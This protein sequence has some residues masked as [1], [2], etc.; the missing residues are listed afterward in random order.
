MPHDVL[1]TIGRN[2]R[3]LRVAAGMSQAALAEKAG[4]ERSSIVRLEQG[5]RN[6]T[7]LILCRI[8]KVLQTDVQELLVSAPER[9]RTRMRIKV[10]RRPKPIEG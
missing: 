3:W 8:A 6:P 7:I 10:G 5:R 2:V 1:W 9:E 4:M